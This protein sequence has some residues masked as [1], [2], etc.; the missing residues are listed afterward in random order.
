M[1]SKFQME[2]FYIHTLRVVSFRQKR[3]YYFILFSIFEFY[4]VQNFAVFVV[5]P[6]EY[7]SNNNCI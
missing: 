2:T 5:E 6:L 4:L 1:I 3:N 7:K